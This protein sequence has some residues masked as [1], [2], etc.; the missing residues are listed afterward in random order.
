[1][2]FAVVTPEGVEAKGS[3]AFIA[4]EDMEGLRRPGGRE[5]QGER[6]RHDGAAAQ[7]AALPRGR[8]PREGHRAALGVIPTSKKDVKPVEV[9]R[10]TEEERVTIA[11]P[12][13]PRAWRGRLPLVLRV[14]PALV[15]HAALARTCGRYRRRR[16]EAEERSLV[17]HHL[18]EHRRFDRPRRRS[19]RRSGRRSIAGSL[20]VASPRR[21]RHEGPDAYDLYTSTGAHL[22]FVDA[23]ELVRPPR[24]RPLRAPLEDGKI[25]ASKRAAYETLWTCLTTS[26]R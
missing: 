25:G 4:R 5:D 3:V 23:L 26:P 19:R 20:R 8:A 11:D 1:M 22:S 24:P 9:P 21:L 15:E 6:S 13:T 7:E 14:E 18:R 2:G 16:S 12:T 10:L 17:L